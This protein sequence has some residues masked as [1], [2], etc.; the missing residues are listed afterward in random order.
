MTEEMV[1]NY[2]VEIS[3]CS[4]QLSVQLSYQKTVADQLSQF[5]SENTFLH[6]FCF[7]FVCE[8]F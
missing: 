7:T 3:S 4:V 5:V 8:L 1:N 2:Q 6:I